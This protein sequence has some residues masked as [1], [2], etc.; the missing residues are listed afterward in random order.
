MADTN[1]IWFVGNLTKDPEKKTLGGSDACKMRIANEVSGKN[2]KTVN[3][4]DLTAWGN[5]VDS[6]VKNLSKGDKI[7]VHGNFTYQKGKGDQTYLN[8]NANSSGINFIKIK[9]WD[10]AKNEPDPEEAASAEEEA[11][12]TDEFSAE[13][14]PF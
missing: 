2:G 7:L 12:D 13:D 10:K 5:G 1:G 3:F 9:S 4:I 14:M 11:A 8:V 6:L